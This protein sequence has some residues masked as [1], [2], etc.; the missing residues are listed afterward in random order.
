MSGSARPDGPDRRRRARNLAARRAAQVTAAAAGGFYLGRYGLHQPVLALYALI[1]AVPLGALAQIPGS[2][3]QRAGATVAALPI[4]LALT[5]TGTAL[6]R[7]TVTAV[8]G[9]VV[10]GFL[11]A[12]A[13]LAG[14]RPA[15][16]APGLQL[17]YILPSFPP[18]A[19]QELGARLAGLAIGILGLAAAEVLLLPLQ[20]GPTYRA[21]L[22]EAVEAAGQAAD[23][24]AHPAGAGGVP[25]PGEQ[26]LRAFG[27]RLRPSRL[28]PAERPA[29]PGRTA[30]ALAQAG[31]AARELLAQL[32]Q[33]Q[34]ICGAP[35][36][37]GPDETSSALL[38]RIAG[39]CADCVATLRGGPA[40]P[41]TAMGEAIHAFQA[42]RIE[43]ARQGGA[44]RPTVRAL[45]RESGVLAAAA[46]AQVLKSSLRIVV[47]G[48][49][50]A[51]LHPA[52]LYW[53][54]RATLP[55]L[56]WH[57][58]RGHLTP[59][60]VYFQ[61]AVR[62]T[63]GLSAARLTAGVFNLAHGFWVLLAVLALTRTTVLHTWQAVRQALLGT[64][65]G[66]LAAAVLLLAAGRHTTAYA[67]VLVPLML[68]AFT[69]GP[70]LGLAWGQGLFTLVVATAFAQLAPATWQLAQTRFLDVAT[71][72][73]IGL[74]CGLLAWPRGAR[75]EVRRDVA[76]L[77]RACG[78]VIKETAAA[79]LAPPA[80][81]RPPAIGPGV[82]AL[83]LA[84]S[85]YA[86]YQNEP[87]SRLA[88]RIDWQ[89]ALI[90]SQHTLLGAQ[91]LLDDQHRTPRPSDPATAARVLRS[92]GALA[93]ECER[94][95]RWISTDPGPTAP[96]PDAAARAAAL[97]HTSGDARS[98][99]AWLR[100]RPGPRT[101]LV[102][103]APPAADAAALPL[104]VDLEHWLNG[105]AVDLARIPPAT[106]AAP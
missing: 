91:E 96:V 13:P 92:A 35:D 55:G 60:S 30:R 38:R 103:D 82:H 25:D 2:G 76:A 79:L 22:A 21:L 87:G 9:M 101:T 19:P 5:A 53:F 31:G 93:A 65:L 29:G 84:Q 40:P 3:R 23:R 17:L 24:L 41:V 27:D 16:A 83:W 10:V 62:T 36:G 33:L 85:S 18:Y 63:L 90:V 4:A 104:L 74:A 20:A 12:L 54:A 14:S 48:R 66:A 1:G 45:R 73:V 102:P 98:D 58:L 43:R 89:A 42:E 80:E 28:P 57:R 100:A 75:S 95:A 47:D 71:G 32:A 8:A 37:P 7:L 6:A 56:W 26:A 88:G 51:P 106:A 11:L 78:P 59:R 94:L 77:L 81:R 105:L 68:V 99:D 64:L 52:E 67:V 72:S 44:D 70:L 50:A 46:P 34:V 49:R 69:Y 15:G 39:A 61:N 97:C 86:Q